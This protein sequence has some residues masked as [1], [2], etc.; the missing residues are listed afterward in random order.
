MNCSHKLSKY[1]YYNKSLRCNSCKQKGKL[2]SHWQGGLP[3]CKDCRKELSDHRNKYCLKYMHKGSRNP[4]Y[5]IHKIGKEAP[6]WQGGKTILI[7]K[8][9]SLKKYNLWRTRI[10]KRDNYT[11]QKCNKSISGKLNVHHIITL[12]NL[13]K[14]YHIHTLKQAIKC[15][16]LWLIKNGITL[17]T[18]CHAKIH[19]KL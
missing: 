14:Q 10:F 13:I 11:C 3:H 8:I 5:N 7:K 15:R 12:S 2:N 6:N 1:A 17:C 16:A 18:K 19:I 4:R 9:A